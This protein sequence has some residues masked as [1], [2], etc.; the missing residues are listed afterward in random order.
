V[1]PLLGIDVR[2]TEEMGGVDGVAAEPLAQH[3]LD[4]PGRSPGL[5][6]LLLARLGEAQ[7]DAQVLGIETESQKEK[8][9]GFLM[10]AVLAEP[11]RQ[12]GQLGGVRLGT[13]RIAH[14]RRL[15]GEGEEHSMRCRV[16]KRAQSGQKKRER[17]GAYQLPVEE[18]GGAARGSGA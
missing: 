6:A 3:V 7:L 15:P 11:V 2:Q 10:T 12:I 18:T 1:L 13:L 16:L 5:Q 4:A 17:H 8:L 9:G 14:I